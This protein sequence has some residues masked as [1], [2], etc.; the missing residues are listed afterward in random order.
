MDELNMLGFIVLILFYGS[1]LCKQVLLKRQGINTNRL[2]RGNKPARTFKIEKALKF[3][4]F[5]MAA[6]Q[7][8]SLIVIKEGDFILTQ[9]SH[10]F[11]RNLYCLSGNRDIYC[12]YGMHEDQLAGGCGYNPEHS[13]DKKRN[14]SHQPQSCIS[15]LRSLLRWFCA[16]FF[17]PFSDHVHAVVHSNSSSADSGGGTISSCCFR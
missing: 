3:A 5:S 2:G 13:T 15:G 10:S 8:L 4:T 7:I 11:R 14:L 9:A 12:S 16:C 6:V 17:Q 1:Y